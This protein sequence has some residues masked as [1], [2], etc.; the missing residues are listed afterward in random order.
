MGTT[1][2]QMTDAAIFPGDADGPTWEFAN[3]SI[4]AWW[5]HPGGDWRDV[6]NTA[7]GN[8]A[9]A[10]SP[11]IGASGDV[12]LSVTALVAR[13][14]TNNTGLYLRST[15]GL[16]KLAARSHPSLPGPRLRVVT[17]TGTFDPPCIVDTWLSPS[18]NQP[19]GGQETMEFPAILKFDLSGVTGTV[20]AATLTLAVSTTYVVPATL[21][22]N[23][24]DSPPLNL[25]ASGSVVGTRVDG[26]AATVARDNAL[27]SHPSVLLYDD[28][29][30]KEYIRSNFQGIAGESSVPAP[31][32][33]ANNAQ[34]IAWPQYGL[35]AARVWSVTTNQRVISWNHWAEPKQNPPKSWQRDFGNGYTHLF[36]RYLMEIGTDVK[37]GMTEQGMKLPGMTGTYDFSNSGAV[38]LPQPRDDGTWEMRLW[39]TG[40]SPRAHPDVYRLSTYFY[41]VDHPLSQFSGQGENHFTSGLVKAGRV[42]SIEQ[43]VKLNT[44]TNGMANADGVERVWVDG[45]LVYENTAI[46]IRGYDHV[47]IQSI[48]FVNIYHGGLGMPSAPFHYDIGGIVVATEYIGPPKVVGAAP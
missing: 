14:L 20:T 4:F 29:V 23:Y 10:T 48:P 19:L 11:S 12:A 28:L 3:R 5:V 22:A 35:S 43:E 32:N 47:R 42:Y 18:S 46:R 2:V 45:V 6:T 36:V 37:T 41:G 39:H 9:Y 15:S 1:F 27:A 34:I 21:T 31:P 33:L 7:Q 24:L 17:T 38:T 44:L 30:S 13:L 16:V 8:A 40:V 25:T 26:I